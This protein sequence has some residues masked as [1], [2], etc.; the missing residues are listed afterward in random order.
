LDH[1]LGNLAGNGIEQQQQ[2]TCA[3]PDDQ[4]YNLGHLAINIY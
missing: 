1:T 2:W 4:Q 3:R